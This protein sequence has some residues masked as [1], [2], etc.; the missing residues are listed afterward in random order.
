[1]RSVWSR[2]ASASITVVAPA[3]CSPASRTAD[4]ICADGTGRRYSIGTRSAVPRSVSGSRS[5]PSSTSRPICFSGSSTRPIGRRDSEASPDQAHRHV[6]AGDQAH[7]QAH[8]GAGV[9]EIEVAVGLGQAADAAAQHLPGIPGLADRAAQRLQRLGRVEHVLGLQQAGDGGA[10]GGER[11]E[12]QGAVR[13]RLVARHPH[14]PDRAG[15]LADDKGL[16][17]ACD[18]ALRGLDFRAAAGIRRQDGPP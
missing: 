13:D 9:A 15:D 14:A 17:V 8:A 3:A 5:P 10:A 2:V 6:V 7:H 11:A 4:L 18:T 16:G 12:H 1:M